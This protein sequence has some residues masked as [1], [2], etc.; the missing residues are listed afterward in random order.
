MD[1]FYMGLGCMS[2]TAAV[3]LWESTALIYTPVA[4]TVSAA[5][6]FLLAVRYW[7]RQQRR[8]S[9]EIRRNRKRR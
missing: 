4:L 7:H 1:D 5:V 9:W 3:L 6:C 8:T 2:L